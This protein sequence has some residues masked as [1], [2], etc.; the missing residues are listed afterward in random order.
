M[1]KVSASADGTPTEAKHVD[2]TAT[3]ANLPAS[4]FVAELVNETRVMA[5]SPC[6]SLRGAVR[7]SS[8]F[9]SLSCRL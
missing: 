5:R 2:I 8:S 4:L 7:R 3:L 1:R 9:N 6:V